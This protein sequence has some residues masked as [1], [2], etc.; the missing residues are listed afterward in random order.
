MLSGYQE[1]LR[2]IYNKFGYSKEKAD[3]FH[4]EGLKLFT[5]QINSIKQKRLID[6]DFFKVMQ[7]ADAAW[8]ELMQKQANKNGNS[9]V[10]ESRNIEKKAGRVFNC[11][12]PDSFNE[13]QKILVKKEYNIFIA[14]NAHTAHIQGILDGAHITAL[15]DGCLLGWDKMG[16]LK[17]CIEYYQRLKLKTKTLNNC[18]VGNSSEEIILAHKA[19]FKTILIKREKKVSNLALNTA[20]IVLNSLT[21]LDTSIKQLF[22]NK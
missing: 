20:D 14:S 12:Y 21:N 6:Q 13:I 16:C 9:S 19:D 22:H 2:R 3:L 17:N 1:V 5:T 4:M 8:D 7:K 18:L 11:F 15:S 10:L